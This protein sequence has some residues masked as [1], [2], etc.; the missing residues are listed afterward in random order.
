[1]IHCICIKW[2]SKFSPEYVNKL[3]RG[4][5][6]NT[7]KEFL[8][9]CY[10][11]NTDGIIKEVK[12]KSIPYFTG[13][14]YSKIGL[15]NEE[16]YNAED[17]I[18][19]FDLDTVIVG[20]MNE[21]FSYTGNFII[22]RDFYRKDGFQSCFMSWR[23]HAV[24]HM[25]KNITREYKSRVGDQGWPEE[26]YPNADLWQEQYPEKVIS[27]K[28]HILNNG[29]QPNTNFTKHGGTLETASV[30]C[31]HGRPLPQDVANLNWMKE[32]WK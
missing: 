24:N 13:D 22:V 20:N 9:T 4:I 29:K 25:W 5:S 31:F 17:Q 32:H 23:P 1:M 21:I 15:Y 26:Q 10:T 12:C 7:S 27:Y 8:F 3:F 19:F 28:V 6:R 30:V 18:F 2:G 11:D 16:L 14:W